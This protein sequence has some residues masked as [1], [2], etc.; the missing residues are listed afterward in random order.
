MPEKCEEK[1][2][3]FRILSLTLRNNGA[4]LYIDV[5]RVEYSS[6]RECLKIM[7][8]EAKKKQTTIMGFR[9]RCCGFLAHA[10]MEILKRTMAA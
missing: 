2:F 8:D 7:N 1:V 4:I 5:A 9:L 6:L 3:L 10:C